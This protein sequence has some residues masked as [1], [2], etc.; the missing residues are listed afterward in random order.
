MDDDA[1]VVDDCSTRGALDAE[2]CQP[3]V[4]LVVEDVH[5]LH[6]LDELDGVVELEWE[7]R[8]LEEE[9]DDAS[10]LEIIVLG[11]SCHLGVVA[12]SR[13]VELRGVVVTIL[14]L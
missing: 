1:H 13:G 3:H 9:L 6:A 7:L 11:A 10:E 5:C 14:S 4:A 2:G 12:V 8:E